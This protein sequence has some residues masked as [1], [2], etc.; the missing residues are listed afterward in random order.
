M[1]SSGNPNS[2]TDAA[3]GVLCCRAA[4]QGAWLNVRINVGGLKDKAFVE[5]ALQE[6]QSLADSA[7]LA[8]KEIMEIVLKNMA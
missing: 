6:G 7:D 8:E 1:V 4:V 5:A 2:V 3:V